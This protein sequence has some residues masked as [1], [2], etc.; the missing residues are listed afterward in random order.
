MTAV[1]ALQA[2]ATVTLCTTHRVLRQLLHDPMSLIM[3]LAV[4]ALLVVLVRFILPTQDAFQRSAPALLGLF[5]LVLVFTLAAISTL[6]ERSAGVLERLMLIAPRKV[7]LYFGYSL[8]YAVIALPSTALTIWISVDW[9]GLR[10]RGPLWPLGLAAL[11]SALFGLGLG[12][13]AGAFAGS[14]MQ[15]MQYVPVLIFP[16]ALLCGLFAPR[17]SMSRPLQAVSDFMP[18]SYAVD[19]LTTSA[20]ALRPDDT[21]VRNVAILVGSALVTVVLGALA[22]RRTL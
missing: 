20:R 8:A 13:L 1:R 4:P 12:L 2:S 22:Q 16:Q 9:L 7:D 18:L 14:E 17:R 21:Y 10:V 5:P 11:A 15:A 6:R 3:T 19:S